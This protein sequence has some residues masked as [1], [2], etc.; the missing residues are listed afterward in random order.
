MKKQ[1]NTEL[2]PCPFCGGR[3]EMTPW[4]GA[5]FRAGCVDDCCPATPAVTGYNEEDTARLWNTRADN[6][7]AWRDPKAELPEP[8]ERVLLVIERDTDGLVCF[9]VGSC[10]AAWR[11][12][13]DRQW[14]LASGHSMRG[15]VVGWLP[16]GEAVQALGS[17]SSRRCSD[18]SLLS[19]NGQKKRPL[20]KTDLKRVRG[21]C[22]LRGLSFSQ[23]L[24]DHGFNPTSSF[25]AL[26]GRRD[27]PQARR[28][29]DAVHAEFGI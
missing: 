24:R 13:D 2:K 7:P 8:L 1:N 15:R 9:A 22:L 25:N 26:Q 23:W 17:R 27:G 5:P 6:R 11:K 16:M 29:R 18:A 20:S 28:V 10:D 4:H 3:A 21:M 19:T 12:K 14:A